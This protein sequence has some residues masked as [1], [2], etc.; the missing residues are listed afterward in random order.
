ML[1]DVELELEPGAE[2]L[3]RKHPVMEHVKDQESK[4]KN[5]TNVAQVTANGTSGP[6]GVPASSNLVTVEKVCPNG[7]VLWL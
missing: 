4:H 5:V 2:E 3:R 7:C 6:A 1:K